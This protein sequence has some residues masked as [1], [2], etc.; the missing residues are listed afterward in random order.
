MLAKSSFFLRNRRKFAFL[1][2]LGIFIAVGFILFRNSKKSI[3]TTFASNRESY[4][5][6]K[7]DITS[8][9]TGS[10]TISSSS[11]KSIASEVSA[12]VLVCNVKVGDKVS[13]GDVLF[14]LDKSS[15]ES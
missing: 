15:L 13:K 4:T 10:G 2:I 1:L 11:T 9:V 6:Q 14:E 7:G 5:V 3:N 8:S 12:D